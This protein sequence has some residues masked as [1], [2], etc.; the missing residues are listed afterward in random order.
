[1]RR[2]RRTLS[3]VSRDRLELGE[4]A[5]GRFCPPTVGGGVEAVI[6]VIVD[7]RLLRLA[8]RLLDGMKLLRQVET[9]AAVREHLDHLVKVTFGALQALDDSGMSFVNMIF[10]DRDSIPPG[11]IS[12][13]IA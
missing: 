2:K 13:E 4:H 7:Q 9:G 12:Q 8:D 11:G 3:Q 1:M 10:H 5:L 6:D